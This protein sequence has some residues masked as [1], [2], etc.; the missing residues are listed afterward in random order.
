MG[1]KKGLKVEV[2]YEVS[3]KVQKELAEQGK[4]AGEEQTAYIIVTNDT[5]KNATRMD[6]HGHAYLELRASHLNVQKELGLG[7]WDYRVSSDFEKRGDEADGWVCRDVYELKYND[8]YVFNKVIESEEDILQAIKECNEQK[9][10]IEQKIKEL[11]KKA[12]EEYEKRRK[13]FI[14]RKRK[15]KEEMERREREE[16]EKIEARKKRLLEISWVKKLKDSRYRKTKKRRNTT[17]LK[18]I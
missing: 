10:S 3:E 14:E 5:L 12:D 17:F 15:E 9:K 16:R 2:R 6:R 7:T 11:Q 13:E 8:N 18:K 1:E 4:F